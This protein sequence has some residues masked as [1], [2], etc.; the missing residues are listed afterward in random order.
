M[1]LSKDNFDIKA[2]SEQFA[3]EVTDKVADFIETQTK[4]EAQRASGRQKRFR[5]HGKT[6]TYA[7]YRNTGQLARNLR[8]DKKGKYK[9]VHDGRR[10]DYSDGSYHG[11]YFLVEKRGERAIKKILKDAKVYTESTKL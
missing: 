7:K 8:I 5:A 6:Y 11:M 3:N 4:A 1:H 2:I 10:S 9:V